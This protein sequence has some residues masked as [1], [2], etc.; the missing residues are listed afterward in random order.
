VEIWGPFASAHVPYFCTALLLG[1]FT[2]HHMSSSVTML[3]PPSPP[4]TPFY[5]L[6]ASS[7]EAQ[8]LT[9]SSFRIIIIINVLCNDI[10]I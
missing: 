5:F 10:P 9:I 2:L 8:S 4:P 1:L 3:S 7:F 6:A